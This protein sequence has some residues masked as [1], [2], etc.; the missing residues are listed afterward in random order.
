M[1][2]SD[3]DAVL[4][5]ASEAYPEIRWMGVLLDG[6]YEGISLCGVQDG[7]RAHET[8]G[9]GTDRTPLEAIAS[10]REQLRELWS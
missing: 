1:R 4:A 6:G 8:A 3:L 9:G 10:I 5:K 7:L 2:A